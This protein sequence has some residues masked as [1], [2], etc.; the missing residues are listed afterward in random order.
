MWQGVNGEGTTHLFAPSLGIN[1]RKA[2]ITVPSCEVH[3]GKKSDDDEFLLASLAGIIGCN[4]IGLL[5]KLTKV[6][7]ANKRSGGRLLNKVLKEQKIETYSKYESIQL[8]ITWGKPDLSRLKK[9]FSL[10]GKGLYRHKYGRN[11]DGHIFCEVMYVPTTNR[12]WH[13]YREFAVKEISRELLRTKE[14]GENPNV[15]LWALGPEDA[16]G[17]SCG[18]LTFYGYLV[19]YLSFIP[20]DFD[21]KNHRS[22]F[23]LAQPATKPV[24]IRKDGRLFRIN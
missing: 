23:D 8:E 1:L 9:C 5:H 22:L 11:F 19:V 14:E 3:N 17:A 4:D 21:F 15:F 18:R 2:L 10:I 13:G 20:K 12:G 6:D 7:R 24:Y 16:S